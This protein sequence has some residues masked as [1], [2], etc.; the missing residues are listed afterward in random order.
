MDP[1]RTCDLLITFL[2]QSNL[3]FYLVESPFS[4][5]IEIRKTFITDKDGNQRTSGLHDCTPS[6]LFEQDKK[7]SRLIKENQALQI[8]LQSTRTELANLRAEFE[9]LQLS[10]KSLEQKNCDIENNTERE[11]EKFKIALQNKEKEIVKAENLLSNYKVSKTEVSNENIKL[12]KELEEKNDELGEASKEYV[13][14]ECTRCI[15]W[16]PGIQTQQM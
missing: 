1:V 15:I 13:K 4:A 10:Q 12:R 14:L 6:Q 2:K 9:Q 8:Q 3:N 11:R 5:S 7:N 16:L